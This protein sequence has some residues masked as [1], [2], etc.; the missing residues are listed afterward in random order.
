[1][2]ALFVVVQGKSKLLFVYLI[3]FVVVILVALAIKLIQVHLQVILALFVL[4]QAGALSSPFSVCLNLGGLILL[5]L[6]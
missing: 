4:N 5:G 6:F 3:I 1:L 2:I